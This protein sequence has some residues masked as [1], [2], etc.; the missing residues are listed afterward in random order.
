MF[1]SDDDRRH[2]G[3]AGE[4]RTGHAGFRFDKVAETWPLPRRRAFYAAPPAR[5]K[6]QNRTRSPTLAYCAPPQASLTSPKTPERWWKR[7]T[8]STSGRLGAAKVISGEKK[9]I[10]LAALAVLGPVLLDLGHLARPVEP[11]RQRGRGDDT[12]RSQGKP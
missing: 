11:G 3:D 8:S 6:P 5:R 1:E 7:N 4:E 12:S 9:C 10:Q 2:G